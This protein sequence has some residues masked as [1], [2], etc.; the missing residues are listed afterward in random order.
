MSNVNDRGWYVNSMFNDQI[1][2]MYLLIGIYNMIS[3]YPLLASF[4]FS[5]SLGIKCGVYLMLP[6]FLGSIQ[7]NYGFIKLMLS[8]AV[9]ISI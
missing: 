7:Y 6:A 8:L 3:N 4:W 9:M 2:T 5:M 1:M